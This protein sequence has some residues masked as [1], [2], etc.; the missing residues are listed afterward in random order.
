LGG[1]FALAEE[2]VHEA[3][4][5]AL[6]QWPAQ[7]TPQ[8]PRAWLLQTA[9]NKAI[10]PARGLQ[11]LEELATL[12][13][14]QAYQPFFAARA[15]LLRRLGR[16]AEALPDYRRALELAK[17]EP[18]KRFVAQRLTELERRLSTAPK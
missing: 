13:E 4:A 5:A 7:G 14:L 8:Y 10:G 1:D 12:G 15:E 17:N 2:V 9:Q 18:E 11:L 3:F 16:L 6:E